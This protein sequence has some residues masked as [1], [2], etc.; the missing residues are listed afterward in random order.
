MAVRIYTM[1]VRIY[2]MAVRIYTM[3]VHIYLMTVHI[4][5]GTRIAKYN[6]ISILRNCIRA[7]LRI[8]LQ[9]LI[10]KF[11]SLINKN[12]ISVNLSGTTGQSAI[13]EMI[14]CITQF[15]QLKSNDK[16]IAQLNKRESESSTA[17]GN[18][19]AIPHTR[20]DGI[21]QVYFFAGVSKEGIEFNAPDGK[22]VHLFF[23][24]ITPLSETATHLKIIS[25]ISLI[26]SN[27]QLVQRLIHANTRDEFYEIVLTQRSE[28]ELYLSLPVP[29]VVLEL[30]T[31]LQGLSEEDARKRLIEHGKNV[32]KSKKTTSLTVKFI[33]YFTNTLALLMWAGGILAFLIHMYSIG[34]AIIAVIIIN[35]LF[36]F[37]QEFKAEKAIEALKNLIPYYTRVIRNSKEMEIPSDE[38][39]P[40]DL[41]LLDEGDNVPADAR[42]IE[43]HELRIDNSV[44]SG[45]SR[46]GYKTTE[47]PS[48]TAEYIWTEIPNLAFAGTSVVSGN[49]KA[50]IIATGISTEIGKI[51]ALT[52]SV[53]EEPST[54]QKEISKLTKLIAAGAIILGGL[55][56]FLGVTIAE[57]SFTGSMLFAI[58]IILGNVPEGLLPTITLSLA[59]AVQRMSKR[60]VLI[61]KLSSVETLGSTDVIC[62]DKTGTLT[63]NQ[64]SVK[65]LLIND[66]TISVSG[67]DYNPIGTFTTQNGVEIRQQSLGNN[68]FALFAQISIL[69]STANLYKKPV[70]NNK[71]TTSGDPTEAALLVMAKKA[72]YDIDDIRNNFPLVKRFPFESI[73]KRM[74]SVNA[75]PDGSIRAFV[76]GAP[77]EILHLSS[78]ILIDQTEVTL[79]EKK[80]L[81]LLKVN[82]DFASEG[83]RILALA[84][85]NIPDKFSDKCNNVSYVE[86]DLT[87]VG[88]A[89]MYD[90][91]RPEVPRAISECIDA[92]IRVIMI[93]GDYE[94]TAQTIAKQVGIVK[95][96]KCLVINGSTLDTMTDE[97]LR[98]TLQDEVIFAR[99]NPEHKYRIV[100]TLKDT[101]KIVA[102]TGDGVNDAPALKKADIGIA[103]GIR[104]TDVAKEA[105]DMIL[106]DDNFAS[107]VAGIEEGRAVFSNI[108]KF[109][110]YIFAHLVPEFIPFAIF[111]IFRTP[112]PITPLQILAIDLGTETLPALALGTEPPEKGLMKQP[113]RTIRSSIVDMKVILHGYLYLGLFNTVFVL[114]I[115]FYV[116]LEGGWRPGVQLGSSELDFSHPLHLKAMTAVF[117]GIVIL[118]IANAFTLRSNHSTVFQIGFFSNKLLLWGIAFEIVFAF[119]IIY[120]PFFNRIFQTTPLDLK[121]ILL[122]FLFTIILFFVEEFRKMRLQKKM[123]RKTVG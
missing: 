16:I 4:C 116:L 73:R 85:K 52:Q 123:N 90:P 74:S 89:A 51:A 15:Y 87:F 37:W 67:S 47:L 5:Y 91:P 82:D 30:N 56:L 10:M 32:L 11:L 46:P 76:K 33:Q 25:R 2:T 88:L 38:V 60:N 35:A 80:R 29:Q 55:F 118:Q 119:V 69:C 3:A 54:I 57:L 63:T 106:T 22:P 83:L 24:F 112:L 101:G 8:T 103:M 31:S 86:S 107:I 14:G 96:D 42:L 21:D 34:W 114:F 110:T 122:L 68:D 70:D 78:S 108:R 6:S 105:A 28:K 65:E 71:W 79:T 111:A 93:T 26:A 100:T 94:L 19:V 49:G 18:G 20:M 48:N 44:F 121:Y 61:K 59:V 92:G 104:G 81:Q 115:Y 36:S 58:G 84:F 113:P 77:K 27:A 1:A 12:L 43:T 75:A 53:K 39:V 13:K 98:S 95:S 62:T 120:I 40:G 45:E 7:P 41:I 102:V 17:I 97:S 23:L 117:A 9:E 72:G 109:I 64:I 50:I 66:Q 99:V